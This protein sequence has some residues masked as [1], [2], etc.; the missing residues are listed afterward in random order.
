MSCP[1]LTSCGHRLACLAM[2]RIRSSRCRLDSLPCPCP[3][4]QND[5]SICSRGRIFFLLFNEGKKNTPGQ[6][7]VD[8]RRREGQ[9]SNA[10]VCIFASTVLNCSAHQ[11]SHLAY[12]CRDTTTAMYNKPA[13]SQAIW[14][15]SRNNQFSF[16]CW[17]PQGMSG[18][19][20][21]KPTS[22]MDAHW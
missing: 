12:L 1:T 7:F 17:Q 13:V 16:F 20:E 6:I 11:Q 4:W 9:A 3:A 10:D 15:W 2:I 21:E 19:A 8:T 18:C 14:G 5:Q 22:L